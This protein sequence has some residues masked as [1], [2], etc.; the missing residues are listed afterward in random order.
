VSPELLQDQRQLLAD[1]LGPRHTALF[2]RSREELVHLWLERLGLA[3][4]SRDP[5]G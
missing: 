4:Q 5:A 3:P 1:E 2:G